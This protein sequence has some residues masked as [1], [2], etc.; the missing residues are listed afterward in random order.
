MINISIIIGG[1]VVSVTF[2]VVTFV[3][4]LLQD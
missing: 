4:S 3:I 2:N 1:A